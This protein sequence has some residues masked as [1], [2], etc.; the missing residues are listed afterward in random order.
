MDIFFTALGIILVLAVWPAL[1]FYA[2][3]DSLIRHPRG[4]V[5]S[6]L[7]RSRRRGESPAT[8]TGF[9]ST[10]RATASR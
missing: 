3:N 5:R 4:S 1:V 7:A 6:W 10:P 8:V 9:R 2:W